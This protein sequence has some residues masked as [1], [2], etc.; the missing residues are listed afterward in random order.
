MTNAKH[1]K[2]LPKIPKDLLK[3][4]HASISEN[5]DHPSRTSY[6][7]IYDWLPANDKI[8]E[9][10]RDNIS[11]DV[12]W[13]IQV[14]S[15]NLPAHKDIGTMCKFNY[16]IAGDRCATNFYDDDDKLIETVTLEHEQW[17]ILNTSVSHEVTGVD[18]VRISVTGRII[19]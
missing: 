17:Y 6:K 7:G 11:K 12:Y 2:G 18:N 16:V 10:C 4:I 14:I 5:Q 1:I 15:D 9:W 8:Q 19:P 3:E 13:G